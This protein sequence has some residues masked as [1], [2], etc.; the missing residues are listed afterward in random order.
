MKVE[1]ALNGVA[2]ILLDTAPVIYHLEKNPLFS[3]AM[4]RFFE[5]RKER[6]ILLVT[7]PITLAECLVHPIREGHADLEETYRAL[8][9]AGEG[10]TFWPIGVREASIAAQLRA[11]HGLA[12][13]D[14]FQLAIA[15]QADCQALLTNDSA[16]SRVTEVRVVVVGDLQP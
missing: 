4:E 3:P 2:S 8:L 7:T 12:L 16:L 9:T 1:D 13:A 15:I 10:T 6:G 5:L 11:K 14:S